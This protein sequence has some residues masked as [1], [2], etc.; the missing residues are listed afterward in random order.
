MEHLHVGGEDSGR[1]AGDGAAEEGEEVV[2]QG[3]EPLG[4]VI[5]EGS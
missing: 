2:L 1:V 5:L 4:V 3:A